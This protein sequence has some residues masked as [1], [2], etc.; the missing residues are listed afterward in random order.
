MCD[1]LLRRKQKNGKKE[2]DLLVDIDGYYVSNP[3]TLLRNFLPSPQRLS[4]YNFSIG[5][6][7]QVFFEVTTQ[8]GDELWDKPYK[9][10]KKIEFHRK[11]VMKE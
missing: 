6:G 7:D 1:N 8:S 5:S 9:C 10:M 4:D 3:R 11:I 2:T